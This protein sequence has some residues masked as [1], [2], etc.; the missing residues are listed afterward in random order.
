MAMQDAGGE[1]ALSVKGDAHGSLKSMGRLSLTSA[2]LS[3]LGAR[4]ARTAIDTQGCG[5]A[6]CCSQ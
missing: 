4:I 3:D 6:A 5:A 1:G 2:R